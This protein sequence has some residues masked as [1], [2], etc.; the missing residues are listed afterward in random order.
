MAMAMGKG[1]G[2]GMGM[3][4][5]MGIDNIIQEEKGGKMS[6]CPSQFLMLK[7]L[8]FNSYTLD[9]PP[10]FRRDALVRG[11]NPKVAK[12]RIHNTSFSS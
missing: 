1:M 9:P 6:F 8:D 4:T 5:G 3:G 10:M 7:R 12:C 2:M 11:V